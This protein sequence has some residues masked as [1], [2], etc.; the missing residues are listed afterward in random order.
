MY[1]S[2]LIL[3]LLVTLA[4]M[5]KPVVIDDTAYLAYA[6]HAA[7]HPG[8]PYGFD[9]YWY[10][11]PESAF[12]VLCPP[13]VPY[14]LAIGIRLFGEHIALLKLWLL[15]FVWLFAAS[16][17]SLLRRFAP[18]TDSRLLPLIV[19][20][21]AVLP[22]VNVMLD[23]PALALGL[24]AVVLF[25]RAG[26]V[27]SWRLAIIAGLLA[28]L[29]MQT[30]YTMLLIPP[31]LGWYGLTHGRF[32][33]VLSVVAVAV[34]IAGFAA[35]EFVLV[36]QYGQSHFLFHAADQAAAPSDASKVMAFV[37]S[38]L[39][40]SGPLVGH[41][42]C[43][44]VGVG[45]VGFAALGVPR[46]GLAT[47][48]T[49]WG[50]GFVLIA[51]LPGSATNFAVATLWKTFGTL[52]LIGGAGCAVLLTFR[53]GKGLRLRW[54]ADSAFLVGWLLLELAGYF[55]LTP[56]GAARRLV[57]LIVVG[58][59]VVGRVLS[60]VERVKPERRTPGWLI[61]FGI[62]AGVAVAAIDAFDAYPEKDCAERATAIVPRDR[63]ADALV[64]YTGHWG[65][66]Y[67]CERAGMTPLVPGRSLLLPGDILVLPIHPN[68]DGF[69][70]P[71]TGSAPIRVPPWAAEELAEVVWE[72]WL[73]ATTV[74][75]FYG[76]GLAVVGRDHPRLRVIVYR[77][78]EPWQV[79]R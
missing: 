43:L 49:A 19:L 57:G 69:Y 79:P 46:R 23:L 16:V 32:R 77:V 26:D 65:F 64:W 39:S 38:K 74:P 40:L 33:L 30:K 35:W 73:S 51:V 3:A 4:N 42:G 8:D 47:L 58:G 72:D 24:G 71:H 29:A 75:N 10:S 18:G 50:V 45:L 22:M 55:A 61:G 59:L 1:H 36:E 56:F 44:G 48:G 17:R 9:I 27:G 5:A 54:N 6:R 41:L 78:I 28:A 12:G 63:P 7:I 70:R 14:W 13:V 37:R 2:P 76:G 66:Q 52:W 11:E 25:I 68:E 20:S 15:P 21:P 34:A 53:L 31:A 60:R 62:G 67:Y